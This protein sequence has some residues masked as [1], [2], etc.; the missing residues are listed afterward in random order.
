MQTRG[1]SCF[2]ALLCALPGHGLARAESASITNGMVGK[3]LFKNFMGLNGHFTFRPKLYR[4]VG[5][6]VR[7][8][9]N[10]NWDVKQP[11]DKIT[12]PVCV[13]QVNWKNDVYGRWQR[14]GYETDLC[15][16]LSGFQADT[17][18]YERFW[19]GKEHWCHDYG[20]AMAGYF[21]PSGQEKLCSSIEIGN[22]PGSK[23]DRVLFKS[24]FKQMAL[25]IRE[26][27]PGIRILT[28]AVQA[29]QGDDYS[30]DLR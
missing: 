1:I 27:D 24:I 23:F 2:I 21:G 3:P 4:Q 6:L 10:L 26:G 29:R 25:G 9:H 18:D 17:A 14:A 30:Q 5:R 11:G 22:E 12:V 16:Q 7:N 28:P 15:I 20:K 8:Y 19:S 13:N